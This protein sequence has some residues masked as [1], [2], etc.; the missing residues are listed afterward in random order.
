[1]I[2]TGAAN[3]I[4]S[5]LCVEAVEKHC[6]HCLWCLYLASLI[7]WNYEF[8]TTRSIR[9]VS[10]VQEGKLTSVE[11]AQTQCQAYLDVATKQL[12]TM[13]RTAHE[14][15]STI[16]MLVIVTR[17]LEQCFNIG[18]IQEA[19]ELLQRLTGVRQRPSPSTSTART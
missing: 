1:M 12:Y 17:Y 11:E 5:R 18:M 10:F 13:S 2:H 9:S 8:A 14:L 19:T 16:G 4:R 15:P 3:V 6:H 7:C